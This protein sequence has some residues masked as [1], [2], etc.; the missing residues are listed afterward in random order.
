MQQPPL[1]HH[2]ALGHTGERTVD[3][4]D[5]ML[6]SEEAMDWGFDNHNEEEFHLPLGELVLLLR[7]NAEG[8]SAAAEV[9]ALVV[10]E[11]WSRIFLS[12]QGPGS[13]EPSGYL[14]WSSQ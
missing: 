11:E 7:E 8:K 4:L 9:R 10:A 1:L 2:L 12:D 14:K 6:R 3:E 13:A 5:E